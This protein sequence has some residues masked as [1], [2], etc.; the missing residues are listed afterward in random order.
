MPQMVASSTGRGTRIW[1][2]LGKVNLMGI[3][4]SCFGNTGLVLGT[5]LRVSGTVSQ[6][7]GWERGVM[8]S[9]PGGGCVL[10]EPGNGRAL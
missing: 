3:N 8:Y 6:E 10:Q 1:H 7:F 4:G 9:L 2:A 5:G